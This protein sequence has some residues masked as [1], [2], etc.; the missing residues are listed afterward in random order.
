MNSKHSK[1]EKN[2]RVFVALF[3]VLLCVVGIYFVLYNR[4]HKFEI[5]PIESLPEGFEYN[6]FVDNNVINSI[7]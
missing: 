2:I 5:D 7:R 1:R 6:D 3:L 4:K